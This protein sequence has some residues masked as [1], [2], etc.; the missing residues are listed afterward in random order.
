MP[1]SETPANDT[2]STYIVPRH[3]WLYEVDGISF[4]SLMLAVHY[5]NTV[6]SPIYCRPRVR[7]VNQ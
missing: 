2:L 4:E 6:C 5:S 3:S 7:T 1:L